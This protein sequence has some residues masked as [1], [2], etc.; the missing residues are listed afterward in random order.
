MVADPGQPAGWRLAA[1]AVK[2]LPAVQAA[3]D[4]AADVGRYFLAEGVNIS[5]LLRTPLARPG[6]PAIRNL[7]SLRTAEISSADQ[8]ACGGVRPSSRTRPN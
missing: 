2:P 5:G 8:G 4:G 1:E 7:R 6:T 3:L